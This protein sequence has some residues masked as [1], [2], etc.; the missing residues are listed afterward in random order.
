[1]HC[2]TVIQHKHLKPTVSKEVLRLSL[3]R[4]PVWDKLLSCK[5]IMN[6]TNTLAMSKKGAAM[7]Q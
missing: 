6:T 4:N 3:S 1:M 2:A 5:R 7:T